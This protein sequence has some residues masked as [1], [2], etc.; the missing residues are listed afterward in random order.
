VVRAGILPALSSRV[1][2]QPRI[3]LLIVDDHPL[4]RAGIAA[5]IRSQDDM[6]LAG[7]AASGADGVRAFHTMQPDV[8]L[9][10]LRL[11][12]ISGVEATVRIR[13]EFP[14]ARIVILTT[15][16]GDVEVRRAL[17]AGARSYVLKSTP[18]TEMMQVI[19]QVHAGRKPIPSEIAASLAEHYGHD[20]LT[21]REVEVLRC[22]A[23]G[24]RNKDVGA[25]LLISEDTVKVHMRR[26]MEKLG[27]IDRTQAVSIAAKRGIIQ[28]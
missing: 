10:D 28:L 24:N 13:A 8:T 11:P 23:A 19:R 3:R 20:G 1:V 26:I 18:L 6:E 7:E 21:A 25:K 17:D 14:D 22:I 9:M 12:D 2:E 5:V 27:A 16:D 4:L 15:F